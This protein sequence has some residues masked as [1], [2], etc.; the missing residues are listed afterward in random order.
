[1]KVERKVLNRV[2][3]EVE[4]RLVW[5]KNLVR[6]AFVCA[7]NYRGFERVLSGKPFMDAL[8]ITPRV[9][10]ICG[11]A[12]LMA[13]VGAIEDAYRKGGVE[14]K[15]TG[16]ALT[17]RRLTLLCELLQNH[18]RWFYL[19]LM[20]D[21]LKLEPSL[22]GL[23][24]PLRG[25]RWKDAL[26][27]SNLPVKVIALFGGQW[28]HTSYAV[29]GGVVCDP[30]NLELSQAGVFL[31]RLK[32]FLEKRLLG[33]ELGEYTSLNSRNYM[34]SLG[35]DLGTFAEVS[36]KNDLHIVGKSYRRFLS[37]GEIEPYSVSGVFSSR[38]QNF[39]LAKV[40]ETE[41]FSFSGGN[42]EAYTWSKGGRYAG[43]P[44][45]TGP[46]ARQVVSGSRVFRSL[47]R[48]FGD[49]VLVRVLARMDE[50]VR[51]LLI[52]EELLEEIDLGE[53]S[54]SEPSVDRESFSGKG[55][56]IVEAARGTLIHEIEIENGRI[57]SY[58]IITPT[59]WNLGP[60]DSKNLGV[61]E[62][63]I[64]G[65]DSELKAEIVLRSFDVCSVCTAH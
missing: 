1:M 31:R 65:L 17:I 45:E 48:R 20:P 14:I 19:Y 46:L 2:E 64:L 37:G 55:V 54:W 3:G 39:E 42:R 58:N 35:G 12:H 22:R 38:V 52:A 41:E 33:M 53:P 23:Y 13:T 56:G 18:L 32:T 50:S 25:D 60:R 59:V 10:G 21:L 49:S 63:A 62:K 51:L 7:P 8:V 34:K 36:V 24:E 29:P 44:Y 6:D 4:L 5:D 27:V 15:L 47:L 30:T 28:P 16:K 43:L 11:H 57:K 9:C 26:A 40:S 61:V